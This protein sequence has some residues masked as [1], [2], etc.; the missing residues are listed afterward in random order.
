MPTAMDVGLWVAQALLAL[1]YLFAGT[2]KAFRYDKAREQMAW[3]RDVPKPLTRFIGTSEVLGGL[4]LVLPMLTGILEWLTVAA[5]LGLAA[6][7]LLAI[8]FHA[9]RKEAKGMLPPAV[10]LAGAVFVAIG[11]WSLF[12]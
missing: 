1:V 11:R 8:A 9:R 5:A 2:T 4:G 6:V 10:L 12:E 3:V 7:M